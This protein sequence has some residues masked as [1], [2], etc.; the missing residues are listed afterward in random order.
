MYE[1]KLEQLE[2]FAADVGK[3]NITWNKYAAILKQ[4]DII[5]SEGL[6]PIVFSDIT[7]TQII[8]SSRQYQQGKFH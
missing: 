6:D 4:C 5:R 3:T 2:K 1:I 7:G 8:I